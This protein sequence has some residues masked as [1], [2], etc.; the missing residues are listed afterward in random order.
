MKK[1]NEQLVFPIIVGAISLGALIMNIQTGYITSYMVSL[2]GL[3]ALALFLSGKKLATTLFY[4][5]IVT[6]L[7]TV[8]TADF[9]YYTNQSFGISVGFTFESQGAKFSFNFIPF[10]YFIGYRIVQMYDLIGKKISIKP[11]KEDSRIGNMEGKI[12]EIV[13]RGKQGKW[14][15]VDFEVPD[16]AEL[17]SVLVKVKEDERISNKKSVLAFIN[18]FDGDQKFIDWGKVRLK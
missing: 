9:V 17:Q 5:W 13:N 15:K 12:S 14:M 7:L 18:S 10:F 1:S 3:A 16:Q 2:I 8:V 11:V 4:I 6:Q